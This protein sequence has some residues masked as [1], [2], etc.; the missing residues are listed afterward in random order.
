MSDRP[1]DSDRQLSEMLAHISAQM[2][3]S[4]G[5]LRMSIDRLVPPDRRSQDE[6]TERDAS[7][8]MQSY[9]RISRLASNLAEAAELEEP[10][11]RIHHNGDIVALCRSVLDKAEQPARLLG[12]ELCL[13]CEKDRH[14]MMMDPERLERLLMNLLSNAFRFAP[15]G[16]RVTV[17]LRFSEREVEL[18]VTD[19]GRGMTAEEIMTAFDRYRLPPDPNDSLQG[20]GLGLPICRRIA[21]EHEGTVQLLSQPGEGTTAVVTLPNRSSTVLEL[22]APVIEYGGGIN[23]TLLE[24]S[25]VLPRQ[26]FVEKF[27]D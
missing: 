8:L 2:K 14:F 17:E 25:D 3:Y 26:A 1:Y 15:K 19:T 27:M 23:T 18:H 21:R 12:L 24:L 4:L 10:P 5:N 20:V 7:V 13:L 11:R 9:Y 6:A 22:H 16:S